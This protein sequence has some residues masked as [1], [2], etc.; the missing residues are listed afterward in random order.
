MKNKLDYLNNEKKLYDYI[1]HNLNENGE[2]VAT[3]VELSIALIVSA[4]TVFRWRHK[5]MAKK[6]IT[7]RYKFIN[8]KKNCIIKLRG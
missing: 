2:L 8:N 5:L 1:S 3:D 6:L 4:M 7:C